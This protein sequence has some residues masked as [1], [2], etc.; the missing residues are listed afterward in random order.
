MP[1]RARLDGVPA[2][3][4]R[5]RHGVV[6]MGATWCRP[7]ASPPTPHLAAGLPP[8]STRITTAAAAAAA[9]RTR[10]CSAGCNDRRAPLPRL[11]WAGRDR[12]SAASRT[13]CGDGG[14]TRRCRT[15]PRF[16]SCPRRWLALARMDRTCTRSQRAAQTP[17]ATH[18][19]RTVAESA[20]LLGDVTVERW[21]GR[22][23][24]FCPRR[25]VSLRR[26]RIRVLGGWREP[27]G[28]EAASSC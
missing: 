4:R 25:I 20:R 11:R 9:V 6:G 5:G 24:K 8:A 3:G 16:Q 22:S 13:G 2:G 17:S 15:R 7:S 28:A 10:T 26:R 19:D 27:G 12:R 18:G 1:R 23:C 21:L 14:E